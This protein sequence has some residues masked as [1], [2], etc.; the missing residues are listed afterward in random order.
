MF[1]SILCSF[2]QALHGDASCVGVFLGQLRGTQKTLVSES[3][4]EYERGKSSTFREVSVFHKF[5]MSEQVVDWKGKS[6]IHFS[7]N[8]AAVRILLYG[9]R[10]PEIQRMVFEITLRCR[11]LGISISAE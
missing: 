7:D 5:Y 10:N 9:S 3:F 1:P 8:A 4:T 2:S 11:E 6:I